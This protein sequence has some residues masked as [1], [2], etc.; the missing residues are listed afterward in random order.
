MRIKR[1]Q[2]PSYQLHSYSGVGDTLRKKRM[3]VALNLDEIATTL[4]IRREYIEALELG[5]FYRIPGKAYTIGFLRTYANF[6]NLD[7]EGVVKQYK[8]EASGR[9]LRRSQPVITT[10][11]NQ[12]SKSLVAFSIGSVIAFYLFYYMVEIS[13]YNQSSIITAPPEHILETLKESR[14]ETVINNSLI[15]TIWVDEP[16]TPFNP[17]PCA[18]I[19]LAEWVYGDP[20]TLLIYCN[21]RMPEY[22][23]YLKL[24]SEF[25]EYKKRA[26]KSKTEDVSTS[27]GN[28]R[29]DSA[30]FSKIPEN[31]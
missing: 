8:L 9:I 10:S 1:E 4:R 7:V 26:E 31:N 27:A 5:E 3:D 12:P 13:P 29:S 25:G 2:K 19:S 24:M 11:S 30:N 14:R 22:Y 15:A 16:I 17:R 20:E 6:L 28:A 21:T 18:G 23:R